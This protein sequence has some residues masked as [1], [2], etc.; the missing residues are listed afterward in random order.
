MSY[1]F[2]VFWLATEL[3]QKSGNCP[4]ARSRKKPSGLSGGARGKIGG[5]GGGRVW[6]WV[7]WGRARTDG[8]GG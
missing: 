8:G 6:V 3:G 7:G 5:D 2:P 1:S 4:S